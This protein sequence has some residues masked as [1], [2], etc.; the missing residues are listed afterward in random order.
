[1]NF[2]ISKGLP[3]KKAHGFGSI[4]LAMCSQSHCEIRREEM[5]ST[6][7]WQW[8][9]DIPDAKAL[10]AWAFCQVPSPFHCL[11]S[12]RVLT[13]AILLPCRILFFFSLW[14]RSS[15]TCFKF[16]SCFTHLCGQNPYAAIQLEKR[17]PQGHCCWVNSVAVA[18]H[19]S[20]LFHA[21]AIAWAPWRLMLT[22]SS[23]TRFKYLQDL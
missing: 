14:S 8:N 12:H 4:S 6:L 23:Q 15:W 22:N 3:W 7:S 9:E 17:W 5:S 21:L 2:C 20:V 19:G 18:F 13:A 11:L 1:M 16:M 10:R